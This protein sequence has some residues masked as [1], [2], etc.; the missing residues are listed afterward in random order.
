MKINVRTHTYTHNFYVNIAFCGV[1]VKL[2]VGVYSTRR[3]D[4]R[5]DGMG[6][7]RGEIGGGRPEWW[8]E[9]RGGG[10]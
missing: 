2:G 6:R 5:G 8:G 4:L 1:K 7:G 10:G 9:G 3:K